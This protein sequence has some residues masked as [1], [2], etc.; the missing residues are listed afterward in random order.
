[1]AGVADEKYTTVTF[2]PAAL[3]P[4]DSPAPKAC[5]FNYVN[6]NDILKRVVNPLVAE[7]GRADRDDNWCALNGPSRSSGTDTP[8]GVEVPPYDFTGDLTKADVTELRRAAEEVPE[9]KKFMAS[10]NLNIILNSDKLYQIIT[11][12]SRIRG[13]E[14]VFARIDPSLGSDWK[15]LCAEA[16]APISFR[17]SFLIRA[18][19]FKSALDKVLGTAVDA[20]GLGKVENEASIKEW[21]RNYGLLHPVNPLFPDPPRPVEKYTLNSML[22][23]LQKQCNSD[24]L[25]GSGGKN[26]NGSS[27]TTSGNGP[28]T[29]GTTPTDPN[30]PLGNNTVS[31]GCFGDVPLV[32]GRVPTFLDGMGQIIDGIDDAKDQ[33]EDLQ[34]KIEEARE[35]EAIVKKLKAQFDAF[36][37]FTAGVGKYTPVIDKIF[38]GVDILSKICNVSTLLADGYTAL[39]TGDKDAFAE[40]INARVREAV[41]DVSKEIGSALGKFLGTAG[42]TAVGGG[43]ASPLTGLLGGWL[44]GAAGE[45]LGEK[46][47]GWAYDTFIAK[48]SKENISDVLFDMMCPG[49]G[50]GS[51]GSGPGIDPGTDPG[52]PILP[53]QPP[54]GTIPGTK[55]P[56]PDDPGGDVVKIL[57]SSGKI[58]KSSPTQPY[59]REEQLK[60]YSK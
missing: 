34:E 33:I 59:T 31:G 53:Y 55:T 20:H 16:N 36:D 41:V 58:L 15:N 51:G 37:K 8:V 35:I 43:I 1:V 19:N 45:W 38:K 28:G 27:G 49:Y 21:D 32:N 60:R 29:G 48:W 44:G 56:S 17:P 42:G 3:L 13:L 40:M 11:R 57:P 24:T 22:D 6:G 10:G 30:A 12:L 54:L 7:I 9:M 52:G 46:V 18:N 4:A 14:K 26:G 25:G 5:V 39:A 2:N 50:G 23:L 47:G